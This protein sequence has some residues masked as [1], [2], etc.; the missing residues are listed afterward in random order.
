M[1]STDVR[2]NVKAIASLKKM[3]NKFIRDMSSADYHS[4]AHTFSSSQFKDLLDDPDYFV[5][6]HI[7]KE[8]ERE[9]N[10]AFDLGT[11]FHTS[12]L[13]PKKIKMDCVVFPGKIRRGK[14]WD[15]FKKKNNGK[16]IITETQK[17][18][19]EGL[20]KAVQ[21]SPVAHQYLQGQAEISLI[22]EI[23]VYDQYIYAPKYGAVLNRDMGWTCAPEDIEKK[24]KS[25]FTIFV[26]VRA[27]M[28]GSDFISDLK[29]TT[30]NARSNRA[31]RIKISDYNYDLSAALYL[32]MFSLIRPAL[33]EFIWIFASK[34]YMN[35]RSYR[36]TK[37]NIRVGRAKFM[38]AMFR[39]RDL[40]RN[41]W[42][43]ID[44]LDE[45][46]PNHWDREYLKDRDEDLL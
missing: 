39:M 11:Y 21:N 23:Q 9:E 7:G 2:E 41:K 34:D 18:L 42:Q 24:S 27:D 20:V 14:D 40:A 45:L 19:A 28:L 22:T 30:G 15:A 3:S 26:K 10:D 12:I 5:R 33:Q 4:L 6:K 31:M 29:S 44:F 25:A 37:D 1:K 8:I 36:A 38:K 13:E 35:S 17:S 46:E 43:T 32:D 16:A